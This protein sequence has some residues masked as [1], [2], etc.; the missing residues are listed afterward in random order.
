VH[1]TATWSALELVEHHSIYSTALQS[2]LEFV[3]IRN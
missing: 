2:P 3:N 1:S